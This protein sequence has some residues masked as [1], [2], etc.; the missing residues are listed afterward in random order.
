MPHSEEMLQR[1]VGNSQQNLECLYTMHGEKS[2]LR[3]L[4]AALEDSTNCLRSI[5]FSLTDPGQLSDWRRLV[6]AGS[7]LCELQATD[8]HIGVPEAVEIFR[9]LR[10]NDTL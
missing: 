10:C 5:G 7:R 2:L 9:A 1:I 6:G 4:A 3:E 8:C